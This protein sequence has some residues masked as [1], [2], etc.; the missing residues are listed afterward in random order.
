MY[1][2]MNNQKKTKSYKDSIKIPQNLKKEL[3]TSFDVIGDVLLI[4]LKDDMINYKKEIAQALLKNHKNVKTVCLIHPVSGELRIRKIE[5]IGGEKVTETIHKE[6]GLKFLVDVKKA[7]FSTRL[8]NE[9]KKITELVKNNE[10]VVDMFTGVAPF[11]IMIAKY[12]KPKIIYAF[13]KNK[14]AIKYAKENIKINNVLDKIELICTDALNIPQY[15]K[16]RNM[17]V[18]RVIMNLPFSILKF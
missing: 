16:E 7:Y 8:A 3:P 17:K 4:K 6:Y 14:N 1:K 9:R 13:D 2:K 10:I 18:D 11:P 15:L 5:I 12:A